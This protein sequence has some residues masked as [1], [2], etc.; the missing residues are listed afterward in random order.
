MLVVSIVT[1]AV[2]CG[3]EAVAAQKAGGSRP[4]R[5]IQLSYDESNDGSSPR[6]ALYAF[7]RHATDSVKFAVRYHGRGATAG[8]RYKTQI[9]DTD[10]RGGK[11]RHPW[12]LIRKGSGGRVLR[13]IHKSLE[14]RGVAKVRIRA[15]RDGLLDDVR[16]RIVLSECAQ[17]PPFYPV[18]CEVRV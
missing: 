6:R 3:G 8:S 18:S 1:S 14:Q 2:T 15:R 11:A 17:D 5:E 9:T 4:P 10:I 16:T 13:L 12:A 7:V